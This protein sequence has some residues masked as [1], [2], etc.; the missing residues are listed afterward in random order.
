MYWTCLRKLLLLWDCQNLPML[1]FV[2][3]CDSAKLRAE[4][5]KI[6]Y[7]MHL[8]PVGTF[9]C[10]AVWFNTMIISFLLM[11]QSQ[12][13]YLNLWDLF[14]HIHQAAKP[15]ITIVFSKRDIFTVIL[16]FNAKMYC[17]GNLYQTYRL[18]PSQF[19]I[20]YSFHILLCLAQSTKIFYWHIQLSGYW[21]P[22]WF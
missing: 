4:D 9:K 19:K 2:M 17:I 21:D 6:L 3:Y 13:Q 14:I 16:N 22:P 1:I 20:V 10:K 18:L 12:L 7:N 8:F 5:K 11:Q 15:F